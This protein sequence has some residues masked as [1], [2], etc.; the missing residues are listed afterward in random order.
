MVAQAPPS[1][2]VPMAPAAREPSPP[3]TAAGEPA[4]APTPTAVPVGTPVATGRPATGPGRAGGSNTGG[5]GR[6]SPG[7]HLD[8]AEPSASTVRPSADPRE[9]AIEPAS[10]VSLG[11]GG[12][13]PPIAIF[14]IGAVTAL[15][16][17]AFVV[18]SART[19]REQRLA[20]ILGLT[21]PLDPPPAIPPDLDLDL[22]VI[23]ARA[24]GRRARDARKSRVDEGAPGA[25]ESPNAPTD[26]PMWVRRLD[27]RI[28][29]MPTIQTVPV[30]N[31]GGDAR[32]VPR[33]PRRKR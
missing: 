21:P 32:R 1:R 8:A 11:V 22:L 4:P 7:A 26:A 17:W 9:P 23:G 10:S 5:V 19:R 20:A 12:T 16:L 6:A 15:A 3:P 13:S 29:V 24:G 18:V 25:A 33:D 28:P 31:D 2:S 27:Q 30:D 14:G